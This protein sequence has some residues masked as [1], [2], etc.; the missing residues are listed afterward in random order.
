MNLKVRALAFHKPLAALMIPGHSWTTNLDDVHIIPGEARL[1]V[2]CLV[3]LEQALLCAYTMRLLGDG[4][5]VVAVW[6]NTSRDESIKSFRSNLNG[7]LTP[8]QV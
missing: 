2:Q 6:G 8:E 3:L 1:A 7:T 4:T 5:G